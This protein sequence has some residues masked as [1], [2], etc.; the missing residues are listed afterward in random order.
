MR[1]AVAGALV[2]PVAFTAAVLGGVSWNRSAGR[3]PT[4]L[5]ERELWLNPRSD[6]NSVTTMSIQWVEDI[7]G[8][9]W[10]DR[11]KLAALGF[12]S[13]VDPDAPEA[14]TYY[15]RQ[16]PRRAYIAFEYDGPAWEKL[17]ARREA[18]ARETQTDRG[19]TESLKLL[20]ERASRLVPVDAG[21]DVDAL[22]RRY[23]DAQRYLIA[24]GVVRLIRIR[25]E[26][27]PALLT[28]SVG[29]IDPRTV[30]VPR[31]VAARIP[32]AGSSRW[33]PDSRLRY[34]VEVWYGR[35]FEPWITSISLDSQ[36]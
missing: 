25:P 32:L 28:G 27:E 23:P 18:E 12:E 20:R 7:R 22:A 19:V 29:E 34:R 5:T 4:V 3:G 11:M 17:F 9:S 10:L 15:A 31:D 35:R 14:E 13:D 6:D 1:R 30:H 26:K 21:L 16:V 24:A 8:E 33:D 2:M 36:P